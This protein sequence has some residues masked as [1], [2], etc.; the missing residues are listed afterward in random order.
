MNAYDTCNILSEENYSVV[1]VLTAFKIL[2]CGLTDDK[3]R[4]RCFIN[5]G[6]SAKIVL[7]NTK[8]NGD[9]LRKLAEMPTGS[10][11]KSTRGLSIP[12]HM[13]YKQP[14]GGGGKDAAAGLRTG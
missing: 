5:L 6:K 10:L 12:H 2:F 9:F 14:G 11:V 7:N 8:A 4:R 3:T 13:T 1:M